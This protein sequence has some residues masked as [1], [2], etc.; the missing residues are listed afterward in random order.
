M[1]NS[2]SAR[3]FPLKLL[4]FENLTAK[5]GKI[6]GNLKIKMCNENGFYVFSYIFL[7]DIIL[8]IE[9]NI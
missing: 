1:L 2:N 4:R 6:T 9:Q 3:M 5:E 8:S 7:K